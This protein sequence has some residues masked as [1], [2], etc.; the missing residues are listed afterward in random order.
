MSSE[1]ETIKQQMKKMSPDEL[2]EHY[3]AA[4]DARDKQSG[5]SKRTIGDVKGKIEDLLCL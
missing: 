2:A 4:T 1:A 3:V 5:T